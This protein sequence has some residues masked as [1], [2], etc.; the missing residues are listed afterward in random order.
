MICKIEIVDTSGLFSFKFTKS[1][2]PKL[3]RVAGDIFHLDSSKI[4]YVTTFNGST[5]ATYLAYIKVYNIHDTLIKTITITSAVINKNNAFTISNS[6][7]VLSDTDLETGFSSNTTTLTYSNLTNDISFDNGKYHDFECSVDG[8]KF[9]N[10]K[11]PISE[12]GLTGTKT[13]TIRRTKNTIGNLLFL[14]TFTNGNITDTVNISSYNKSKTLDI[15]RAV[16]FGSGWSN[17]STP[18]GD[19]KYMKDKEGTVF[20]QG[21]AAGTTT[22]NAIFVL[23]PIYRPLTE[24]RFAKVGNS[25]FNEIKI[26]A[27]GNVY[28]ITAKKEV[29][30]EISFKI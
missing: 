27:S 19:V 26:D 7:I 17:Y 4:D 29:H 21:C 15:F 14:M 23:P 18:Y 30:L 1:D 11:I 8:I 2:Y 6:V 10:D 22:A 24:K 12:L 20:I 28:S 3:E 13:L 5:V 16:T 25:A 9:F